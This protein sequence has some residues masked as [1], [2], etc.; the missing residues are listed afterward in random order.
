MQITAASPQRCPESQNISWYLTSAAS[1][2]AGHRASTQDPE[3]ASDT[4]PSPPRHKAAPLHSSSAPAQQREGSSATAPTST[5]VT[6]TSPGPYVTQDPPRPERQAEALPLPLC[7]ALDSDPPMAQPQRT[8]LGCGGMQ[9]GMGRRPPGRWLSSSLS[10]GVALP[11]VCAS[12]IQPSQKGWHT[13]PQPDQTPASCPWCAPQAGPPH[14]SRVH[15]QNGAPDAGGTL[16]P[17]P[18]PPNPRAGTGKATFSPVVPTQVP[19]IPALPHSTASE[20]GLS[21][22]VLR[23]L[24]HR[25]SGLRNPFPLPPPGRTLTRQPV[26]Y[27][28]PPPE[29]LLGTETDTMVSLVLDE[30]VSGTMQLKV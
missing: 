25:R 21:A 3:G 9:K 29:H 12:P 23:A 20:S 7:P 22:L 2:G 19:Q 27:H 13:D 14:L 1:A 11:G 8:L 10:L 28:L 17:N 16:Y 26:Y 15:F 5:T 24:E 18:V 6:L 4:W 30:Q